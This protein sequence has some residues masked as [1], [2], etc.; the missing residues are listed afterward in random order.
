MPVD[1]AR[2]EMANMIRD[3][4]ASMLRLESVA[5]TDFHSTQSDDIPNLLLK[6]VRVIEGFHE[7]IAVAN[8]VRQRRPGRD[9]ARR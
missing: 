8:V 9:H 6:Y 3:G 2:K 5:Y 7:R 1:R 4:K